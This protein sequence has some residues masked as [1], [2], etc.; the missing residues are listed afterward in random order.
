M[1]L[2]K[3]KKSP[4]SSKNIFSRFEQNKFERKS[5]LP[6]RGRW[7]LRS[8]RSK[9]RMRSPTKGRRRQ[10]RRF[11][12]TTAVLICL[13]CAFFRHLRCRRFAYKSDSSS[14]AIAVPLPRWGRLGFVRTK[15]NAIQKTMAKHHRLFLM[16]RA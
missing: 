15:Y 13:F 9:R 6:Q 4:R 7:I 14:T 5:N 1:V 12:Q 2:T 8:L 16:G 10:G 11:R 3:L